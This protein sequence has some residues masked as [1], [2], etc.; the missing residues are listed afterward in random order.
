M[1]Y[2]LLLS[3]PDFPSKSTGWGAICLL[4]RWACCP[5][6][7]HV[8][9]LVKNQHKWRPE[10]DPGW[11]SPRKA[12]LFNILA[13]NCEFAKH[14]TRW[15]F[16]LSLSI[17]IYYLSLTMGI[18]AVSAMRHIRHLKSLGRNFNG[19][20][21]KSSRLA[22]VGSWQWPI[23]SSLVNVSFHSALLIASLSWPHISSAEDL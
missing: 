6:S 17:K 21:S 12:T 1:A 23:L 16:P 4:Q 11:T 9:Q 10:F 20:V 22:E 19:T 2:R 13:G 3:M 14:Q 5:Y 8:V 18:L 15:C 7:W